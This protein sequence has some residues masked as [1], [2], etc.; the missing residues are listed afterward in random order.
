MA[1][2]R[3][4]REAI[5]GLHG[6]KL[7]GNILNVEVSIYMHSDVCRWGTTFLRTEFIAL[8]CAKAYVVI[9]V[10]LPSVLVSLLISINAVNRHWARLELGWV[11]VCGQ[12]NHLDM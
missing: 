6:S 1:D 9:S 12:V 2:E 8:Y 11:T 7:K 4:A 10:F 3:E 5:R